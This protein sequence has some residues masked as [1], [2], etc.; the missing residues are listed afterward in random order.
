MSII[1]WIGLGI[2]VLLVALKLLQAH[3]NI[4]LKEE[5]GL[6]W[7]AEAELQRLAEW[8]QVNETHPAFIAE[9]AKL[10]NRY[11]TPSRN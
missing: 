3:L 5:E 8:Y 7:E 6:P 2:L 9:R 4:W 1:G 11:K 10:M